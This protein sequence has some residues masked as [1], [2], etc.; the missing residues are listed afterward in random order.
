MYQL[1]ERLYEDKMSAHIMR[2]ILLVIT[3]AIFWFLLNL[4]H[5]E[6]LQ[7]SWA[8]CLGLPLW[9]IGILC[10]IYDIKNYKYFYSKKTSWKQNLFHY[11]RIILVYPYHIVPS[12]KYFETNLKR[13]YEIDDR[14]FLCVLVF[15]LWLVF[16][17]IMYYGNRKKGIMGNLKPHWRLLAL[18]FQSIIMITTIIGLFTHSYMQLGVV[19]S[20]GNV[21]QDLKTCLYFS[22]VT[23][24]TL[25]YGDFS[26]TKAARGLAAFQSL[27][28]YLTLG[29]LIGIFISLLNEGP[30]KTKT[31]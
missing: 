4:T 29:V 26:P 19:D 12:G 22:T 18:A 1:K 9:C 8:F 15:L 16:C 14:W 24:S 20:M 30:Q 10:L 13:T 3:G 2:S 5:Q 31:D 7:P 23:F 28:G 17:Y 6:R 25:G 11:L 27:M 21:Q